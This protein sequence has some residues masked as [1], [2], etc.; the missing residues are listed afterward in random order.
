VLKMAAVCHE[1]RCVPVEHFLLIVMYT[2]SLVSLNRIQRIPHCH[3]GLQIDDVNQS[4]LLYEAA[5]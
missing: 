1:Q 2:L 3:P 5:K 4:L